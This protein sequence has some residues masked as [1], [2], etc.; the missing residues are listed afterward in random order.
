MLASFLITFREGLEAFLIVGIIL[1]YLG[2]MDVTKYNKFVYAGVFLGI[3]VSFVIAYIFQVVIYDIEDEGY[4]HY[5][6]I[7][8]L[9]FATAVLS[10]MVIWMANQS[11][12][13]KGEME[14]HLDR[15]ITTENIAGMVFLAFLAVLRE[16]VET[17]LFFSS[18]TIGENMTIQEG[19]I[20]AVSGLLLSLALVYALMRGVKNIPIKEFFKY[21]AL[22][23]LIIAGGLFGSAVSMMQATNIL[24]TFVP[25]IYDISYILDDRSTFGIFLRALF[26]YNSSPSLLHFASWLSYMSIAIFLW[27]KTYAKK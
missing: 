5:L 8:I 16:G 3:A 9:L 18:L 7:T 24:P 23:I 11:R 21:S 10:Y 14:H 19:I 1:S 12:E 22:L 2:K 20:G 4:Q 15:L 25:V 6:M 13:I 17:V 26:G 27:T